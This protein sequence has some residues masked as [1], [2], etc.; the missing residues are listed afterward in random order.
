ME[1]TFTA[2][3]TAAG[4]GFITDLKNVFTFDEIDCDI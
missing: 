1:F 2:W 4:D 3:N